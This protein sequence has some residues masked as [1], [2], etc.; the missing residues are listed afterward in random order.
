MTKPGRRR[1]S[2]LTV[3]L[4]LVAGGSLTLIAGAGGASAPPRVAGAEGLA[5]YDSR[6]K[7]VGEVL[8]LNGPEPTIVLKVGRAIATFIADRERLRPTGNIFDSPLVYESTDCTGQAFSGT[9]SVLPESGGILGPAL[10][11]NGTKLYEIT[12]EVAEIMVNSVLNQEGVFCE[13]I[14]FSHTDV[15]LRELVDLGPIFRP[16]FSVRA[17]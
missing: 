11:M 15:P 8:G 10:I 2:A 16:P 7:F 1:L 13:P 3:A 9:G 6:G 5:V 17:R 12:G 14:T 4:V